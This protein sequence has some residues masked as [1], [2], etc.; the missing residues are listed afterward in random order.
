MTA[1]ENF[2]LEF[3]MAIQNGQLREEY[4][5]RLSDV[6]IEESDLYEIKETPEWEDK[7]AEYA[8]EATSSERRAEL[9]Q[10]FNE[11]AVSN[12]E[13]RKRKVAKLIPAAVAALGIN[14]GILV[15]PL[16][17]HSS[18]D[19]THNVP[20]K[21]PTDK[22]PSSPS[23]DKPDNQHHHDPHARRNRKKEGQENGEDEQ[24]GGEGVKDGE[25]DPDAIYLVKEI[26]PYQDT[27]P[28]LVHAQVLDEADIKRD[29]PNIL[30]L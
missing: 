10:Y 14:V 28:H 6:G 16:Q 11:E 30:S 5:K 22:S 19:H 26:S 9:D 27:D 12:S 7:L 1:P 3:A 4:L 29:T 17:T 21:L 18:L 2:R 24:I 13:P 15:M 8:D 25:I 20:G 23:P